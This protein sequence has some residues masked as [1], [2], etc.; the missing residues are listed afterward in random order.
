EAGGAHYAT[1]DGQ[2]VG[3]GLLVDV[4]PQGTT[5]YMGGASG[6]VDRNGA[7]RGEVD[8]DPVV[9]HRGAGHV[10]ASAPYR[11]LEVAVPC[12]AHRRSH[13]GYPGAS[14]DQPGAP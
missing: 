6:G 5:L 3:L 13:V 2:R 4:A 14:G 10:V 9:A 8:D 11:D 12:E 7:H 1:G